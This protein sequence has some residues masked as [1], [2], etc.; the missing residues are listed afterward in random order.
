MNKIE[1]N[2]RLILY[3]FF[4]NKIG[5]NSEQEKKQLHF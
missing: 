5:Q 2:V 4:K 3:Y 1:T